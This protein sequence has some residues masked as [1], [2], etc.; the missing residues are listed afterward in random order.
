MELIKNDKH[1]NFYYNEDE[2]NNYFNYWNSKIGEP[3]IPYTESE[4]NFY[5]NLCLENQFINDIQ[6]YHYI[7]NGCFC[8]LCTEKRRDIYFK[9]KSGVRNFEKIIHNAVVNQFKT[10][11]INII[12]N[13][14]KNIVE[15]KMAKMKYKSPQFK[16]KMSK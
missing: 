9:Y 12:N 16:I 7:D 6:I 14:L 4:F 1:L 5:M 15:N 13:K 3:F 11:K 2:R 8:K 10:E